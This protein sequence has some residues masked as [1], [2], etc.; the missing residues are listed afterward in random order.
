MHHRSQL[1]SQ[2]RSA[3][4]RVVGLLKDGIASGHDLL[5]ARQRADH[6]PRREQ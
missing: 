1:Y 3:H 6:G 5:R 2:Q 4:A